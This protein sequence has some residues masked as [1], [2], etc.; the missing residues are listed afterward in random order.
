V[1][2]R[3]RLRPVDAAVLG[4]AAAEIRSA[5]EV[6]R[7][8]LRRTRD[9]LRQRAVE[10]DLGGDGHLAKDVDRAIVRQDRHGELVDDASRVGLLDHLVQR[11]ARLALAVEDRPVHR[12]APAVLGQERSVHV[13]GAAPRGREHR[14]GQH[15]AVIE[16]KDEVGLRDGGRQLAGHVEAV[17][18]RQLLDASE[19][20]VLIRVVAMGHHQRHAHA[21]GEEHREAAHAHV[22]IGEDDGARVHHS[23]FSSSAWIT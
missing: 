10:H 9:E 19:P 20:H 2:V 4:L 17:L 6:L 11:R 5:R 23:V 22:V 21:M 15:V 14:R 18:A 8:E 12:G 13:V 7:R 1:D 16:R 3:S